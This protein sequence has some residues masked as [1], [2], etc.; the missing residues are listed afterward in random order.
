MAEDN[1][2]EMYRRA[3]RAFEEVEFWPQEK[4]D[5]MV[6]AVAWEWQKDENIKAVAKLAVEV[7]KIGVYEDKLSK[8]KSETRGTMWDF[9]GAKTCGLVKEEGVHT[10]SRW[11]VLMIAP[12]LCI[13]EEELMEGVE[14]IDKALT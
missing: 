13:N 8:I 6:A 11:N 7:G 9:R 10:Y 2:Q 12:P 3:R 14:K 4:V 1:I 5:E